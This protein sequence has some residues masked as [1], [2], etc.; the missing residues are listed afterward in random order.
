MITASG[1][2][3]AVHL[4]SA[5]RVYVCGV[6]SVFY[7]P[8]IHSSTC[9]VRID[10]VYRV[11]MRRM[12]LQGNLSSTPGPGQILVQYSLT[13]P[14]LIVLDATTSDNIS[15]LFA[16][17]SNPYNISQTGPVLLEPQ[18]LSPTSSGGSS[19]SSDNTV[20]IAVGVSLG[21]VVLLRSFFV[22]LFNM[23]LKKALTAANSPSA[24]R[25]PLPAA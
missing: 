1:N 7:Y 21:C 19:S 14:S 22:K 4:A 16:M 5:F 13:K 24:G 18:T 12:L 2:V 3:D 6:L 8:E 25:S 23:K 17:S 15:A 11:A 10:D 20:G 9:L